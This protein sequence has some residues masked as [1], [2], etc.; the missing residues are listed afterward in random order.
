[1]ISIKVI[2]FVLYLVFCHKTTPVSHPIR[3]YYQSIKGLL[4][5]RFRKNKD[6]TKFNSFNL[7]SPD[8]LFKYVTWHSRVSPLE[9][10]LFMH[11]NNSTYFVDLDIARTKLLVRLFQQYWWNAYE[12]KSGEFGKIQNSFGNIPYTPL[13]TVQCS[14][15]RELTIFEKYDVNSRILAWDKKW[16]F[17]LS[18]FTTIDP[19]TK[20]KR[21]NAI[22]LT[23]YVFKKKRLTVPPAEY[24]GYCNLLDEKNEEINARNYDLV[25][26]MI[27]T[28][29]LDALAEE[30]L[31]QT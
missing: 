20:G 12:N 24:L 14:F 10:D 5:S 16:L 18:T 21:T 3:F 7:D 22:A 31:K 2:L 17:V 29:D 23:K 27:D 11:K 8:K 15:K 28:G 6:V 25:K 26:H 1:M 19:K 13:G 30:F 4:P 9:I